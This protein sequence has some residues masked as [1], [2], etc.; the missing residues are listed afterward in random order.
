MAKAMDEATAA[1][2]T[3][4]GERMKPVL[5]EMLPE[6]EAQRASIDQCLSRWVRANDG[7]VDAASKALMNYVTWYTKKPQYGQPDGVA[8]VA[9]GKGADLVAAELATQKAFV[10]PDVRD[11][12]G[13]PVILVQVRKHDPKAE[14]YDVDQLTLFAVQL[15]ESCIAAMD[16]HGD[17]LCCVF[18]LRSIGMVNVD[19]KAVKRIMF[20][21]TNMYPERL[22]KCWLLDAPG[23]FSTF[24][25]MISVMLKENTTRKI[26]FVSQAALTEAFGADS[27]V[28]KIVTENAPGAEA[29]KPSEGYASE[30]QAVPMPEADGAEPVQVA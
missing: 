29:E 3:K 7:D 12:E 23:L 10:I 17:T 28:I 2:V 25:A 6:D 24:W 13:R 11:P 14:G 26:Q 18:D 9:Q 30:K 4:L 19:M 1:A 5:G 20:L 27:Q 8:A 21:L 16:E 22:G 15:I